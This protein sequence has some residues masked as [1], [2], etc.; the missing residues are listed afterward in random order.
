MTL[1]AVF[2]FEF[3]IQL[4]CFRCKAF[5]GDLG[6]AFLSPGIKRNRSR[7]HKKHTIKSIAKKAIRQTMEEQKSGWLWNINIKFLQV[8]KS[9]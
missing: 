7:C 9:R 8:N 5:P 3:F 6:S 1:F 4:L 2:S